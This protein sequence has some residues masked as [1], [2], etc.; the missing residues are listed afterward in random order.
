M[1]ER[2]RWTVRRLFAPQKWR[3]HSCDAEITSRPKYSPNICI[4]PGK[5]AELYDIIARLTLS[6][7]L[8]WK[9]AAKGRERKRARWRKKEVTAMYDG[10]GWPDCLPV[11][12]DKF[13]FK[14]NYR[15]RKNVGLFTDTI[16]LFGNLRVPLWKRLIIRVFEAGSRIRGSALKRWK[17]AFAEYVWRQQNFWEIPGASWL[18]SLVRFSG[19]QVQCTSCQQYTSPRRWQK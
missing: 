18:I 7:E 4:R 8:R 2:C 17:V 6:S 11:V 3:T 9:N 19:G 5:Q 12:I 10:V 15:V 16:I 14:I 13:Q 1:S